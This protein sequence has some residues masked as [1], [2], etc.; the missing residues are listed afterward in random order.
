MFRLCDSKNLNVSPLCDLSLVRD[1]VKWAS[2]VQT[3]YGNENIPGY[4][5][6]LPSPV[7]NNY[8]TESRMDG[9]ML[10]NLTKLCVLYP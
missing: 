5:K 6:S 7:R 8:Y 2:D 4:V 1:P 9:E 3:L 10:Q